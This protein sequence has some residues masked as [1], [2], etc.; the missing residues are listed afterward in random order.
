MGSRPAQAPAADPADTQAKAIAALKEQG[1]MID[2]D[3]KAPGKPAIRLVLK[4][5]A[6]TDK[7]LQDVLALSKLQSVELNDTAISGEGVKKLKALTQLH[8]L[9]LF[10][11]I[12]DDDD[13]AG[14]AGLAN[15]QKLT[16]NKTS[17]TG[18]GLKHLKEL[19][20][21]KYLHL[22]NN[23]ID[24]K[25]IVGVKELTNL[26]YLNL[27]DTDI[28]NLGVEQLKGLTN[29]TYLN[30]MFTKMNSDAFEHLTGM[31]KL[32]TLYIDESR[33]DPKDRAIAALKKQLP[34]LSIVFAK[35]AD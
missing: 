33:V 2:Q 17:I 7:A 16:L 9:V 27:H 8:T 20:K 12:I 35:K 26:E 14:L 25:G 3:P 19:K 34:K 21:L 23:K 5:Q 31:D 15:L 22:A 29:L 18:L 13:L 11:S 4:G 28:T 1:A 10:D 32:K 24:N 6:F 30:L